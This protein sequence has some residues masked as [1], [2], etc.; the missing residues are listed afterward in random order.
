QHLM[1]LREADLVRDRREGLM[2]YYALTDPGL[3]KLVDHVAEIARAQGK[4][5]DLPEIPKEP[6]EGCPCPQCTAHSA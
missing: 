1:V 3:V 5:A 6:L 2:V 4:P